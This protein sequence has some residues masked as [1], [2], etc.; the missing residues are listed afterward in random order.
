MSEEDLKTSAGS[1]VEGETKV[2][3]AMLDAVGELKTEAI[4]FDMLNAELSTAVSA[5]IETAPASNRSN[6]LL[7]E[8]V[9]HMVDVVRRLQGIEEYVGQLGVRIDQVDARVY[10]TGRSLAGELAAQRR[11]LI[12]ERKNV[13]ARGLFNAVVGHLDSLRAMRAALLDDRRDKNNK[14]MAS[15]I[16]AVEIT[17]L[18]ALQGMGF[19]EFH[20][21]EGETFSP[22]T[23]EC[24]GYTKGE[25]GIVLKAVRSGFSAPEGVVRAA[26]VYI[27]EPPK[28]STH[29][30]QTAN[31]S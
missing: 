19:S 7:N 2:D 13:L 20:T 5:T 16:E 8:L 3:P 11:E 30:N 23:M 9:Q 12:G 27:G 22:A 29:S 25:P 1:D 6:G 18:T 15:L 21:R 4:D 31:K 28:N 10:E 24:L 17:L 26:G 14:R